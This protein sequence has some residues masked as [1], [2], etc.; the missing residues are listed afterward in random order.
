MRSAVGI[1]GGT[2][3]PI[4][5]GHLRTAYELKGKLGLSEVLFVPGGSPP[6]RA[7]P[8]ASGELRLR[9]VTAAIADE[10]GFHV[11]AREL[12][13]SGPSYT[14]DTLAQLRAERPETPL[15]LLLGMDAFL[16]L[17]GWHRWQ[18]LLDFAHIAVARR[19]GWQE[20]P[21]GELAKLLEARRCRERD[22]LHR[23]IAGL[24]HVEAVTQLEISSAALRAA[25]REGRDGRYLVPEPVREIAAEAGCYD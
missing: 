19:P 11:D 1:F 4:H 17:A 5:F 25:M 2:F 7:P 18:Q 6:H 12:K 13:R 9:M 24:I 16:G 10:P 15:C 14:V 21:S 8:Q 3:D 22:D 20:Q 23:A